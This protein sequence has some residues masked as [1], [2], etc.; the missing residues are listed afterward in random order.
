MKPL[1]DNL[2]RKRI[3]LT[4]GTGF[5]GKSI[6]DHFRRCPDWNSELYIL[7]RNPAAFKR[8]YPELAF[9]P[10][11]Q[12]MIGDVRDFDYSRLPEFDYV[13]HAATEADSKFTAERPDEMYSVIVDGTKRILEMCADKKVKR[14]LFVSS[15]A[16]YGIQPP[17]LPNIPE[18]YPCAPENA[19]GK[20]K[21]DAENLCLTSDVETVIARCFAFIGNYFPLARHF[22]IGNFIKNI[23]NGADIQILGDGTPF[24]SYLHSTDLVE[25]LLALL[26]KGKSSEAYNVGSDNAVSIAALAELVRRFS[27]HDIKIN[28]AGTPDPN[29]QPP[30]YVPDI[31]KAAGLGLK[32]TIPLEESIART[33]AYHRQNSEM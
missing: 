28:I 18:N 26:V 29:V 11:L 1:H 27:D 24:R 4:G 2:K 14:L 16:V 33:I 6:L 5:F 10:G 19:Y 8:N 25:W 7:S 9:L 21:L 30:R 31:S 13:I 12:F 32:M 23:L 15:G 3:F 22:A 20:G 17:E